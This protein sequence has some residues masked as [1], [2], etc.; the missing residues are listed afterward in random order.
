MPYLEN[1]I[2]LILIESLYCGFLN[3]FFNIFG[4]GGFFVATLW[5][6][7]GNLVDNEF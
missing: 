2:S 5:F 6:A 7:R 1:L 4:N 3:G